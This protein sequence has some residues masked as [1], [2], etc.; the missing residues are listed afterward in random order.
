MEIIEVTQEKQVLEP[1]IT[2]CGESPA[3]AAQD[4]IN[5]FGITP[6]TVYQ[7]VSQSGRM[8]CYVP[9]PD[10][11]LNKFYSGAFYGINST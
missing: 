11:I 9:A 10:H 2:Y 7:K 6:D 3:E 5:K 8:T 1:H 4:F